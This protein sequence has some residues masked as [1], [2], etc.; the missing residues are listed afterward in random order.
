MRGTGAR[1]WS[2]WDDRHRQES[3]GP[4][5]GAL[6]VSYDAFSLGAHSYRVDGSAALDKL[7]EG[8]SLVMVSAGGHGVQR[9]A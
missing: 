5:Y 9:V 6:P 1:E 2:E 8:W 7:G 4:T 3:G